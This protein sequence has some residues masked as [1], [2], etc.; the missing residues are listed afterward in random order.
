VSWKANFYELEPGATREALARLRAAS[1]AP[2]PLSFYDL[3]S[4]SNGGYWPA[5]NGQFSF[6]L[7]PAEQTAEIYEKD[8]RRDWRQPSV[9]NEFLDGFVLIGTNGCG[10]C[11]GFDIRGVTPWP[12]VEVDTDA[13][14]D[15]RVVAVARDF[16]AFLEILGV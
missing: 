14:E 2:L 1:P 10:V 11:V 15:E 8:W 3:L 9:A 6:R 5:G 4:F 16:D 7:S 13:D 12:I